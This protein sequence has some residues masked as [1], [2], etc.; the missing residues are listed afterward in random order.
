MKQR[1]FLNIIFMAA[2]LFL[3]VGISQL[4]VTDPVESNYALTALEMVRSGDWLSRR[5][6]ARTGMISPFSCTGS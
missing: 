1:T 4:A 6:T 3:A 5:F 2:F